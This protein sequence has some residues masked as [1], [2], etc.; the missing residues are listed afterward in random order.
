[1]LSFSFRGNG[2]CARDEKRKIPPPNTGFAER[3]K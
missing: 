3:D 2:D 1:M